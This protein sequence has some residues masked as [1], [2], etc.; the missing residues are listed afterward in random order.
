MT[1][2]TTGSKSVFVI[3]DDR[4]L[5]SLL[6]AR[7]ERDGFSVGQSFDGEEAL[8][9]LRTGAIKPDLIVLD[10]I[11]PR[12]SGFEVLQAISADI[13]LSNSLSQPL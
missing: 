9:N 1:V 2:A 7:L 4:F 8:E 12:L 13:R 6:K 11:M 5:S 10:L 3:E